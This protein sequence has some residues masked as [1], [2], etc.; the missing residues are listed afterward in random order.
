MA[1]ALG[2]KALELEARERAKV[3]AVLFHD[4]DGTRADGVGRWRQIVDSISQGFKRA[5][6]SRG[7][8]MVPKPKQ[9]AWFLCALKD[10]PYQACENLENEPG[11][12]ASPNNLKKQ[13]EVVC[14]KPVTLSMLNDLVSTRA[15]DWERI[16]M[17]SLRAFVEA[18][19]IALSQIFP[20][21][22]HES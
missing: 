19:A 9:E 2:Q 4:S 17:P 1:E 21:I 12:D 6:F 7:V 22:R 14:G 13:L 10:K 5:G 15:V 11:N 16:E 20:H 3:V 8:P 18:M